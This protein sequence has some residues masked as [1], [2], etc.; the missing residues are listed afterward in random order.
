MLRAL[1]IVFVVT[2]LLSQEQHLVAAPAL[3]LRY[4]VANFGDVNPLQSI[5]TLK[6]AGFDYVEPGLSLTLAPKSVTVIGVRP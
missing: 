4:G 3:R 5:D 6:A 1:L 2:A